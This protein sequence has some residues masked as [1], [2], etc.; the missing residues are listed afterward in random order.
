MDFL[1]NI[2]MSPYIEFGITDCLLYTYFFHLL[3]SQEL[4]GIVQS[5]NLFK[6]GLL[7]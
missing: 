3:I 5:M 6:I 4:E 2:M 7:S 1:T